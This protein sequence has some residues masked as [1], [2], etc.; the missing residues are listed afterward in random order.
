LSEVRSVANAL[1][2]LAS[3]KHLGDTTGVQE[4]SRFLNLAPSV[5]HR[6]MSTL[7]RHGFLEQDRETRKYRIGAKLLEV[8]RFYLRR[9]PVAQLAIQAVQEALPECACFVGQLVEGEV[10]I[11]AAAEGIGPVSIGAWPGERRYVHCT[12]LGKALL[13]LMPDE[14]V[15]RLLQQKGMPKVTPATIT[16]PAHLLQALEFCRKHGF[17]LNDEES[18]LGVVSVGVAITD[19]F[20]RPLGATSVSAAKVLVAPEKIQEIGAKLLEAVGRIRIRMELLSEMVVAG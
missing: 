12:A 7:L 1:R 18:L 10:L 19:V 2:V 20:G 11:L 13:A 3:F 5:T 8:G 9:H 15:L 17:A 16:D 6:L 4:V 14:E